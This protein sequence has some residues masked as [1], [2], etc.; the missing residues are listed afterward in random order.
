[1][2]PITIVIVED[3][4]LQVESL[5][6]SLAV[7]RNVQI[8]EIRTER[9]FRVGFDQ[10]AAAQPDV[11]LMDVM[12]RWTDPAPNMEPPPDEVRSQKFYRAGLRCQKMLSQDDRTRDIPVCL[13]TVLERADLES[14]LAD[15]P[16]NVVHIRKESDTRTL[17]E[18]L[19]E[20]IKVKLGV[21]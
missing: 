17:V 11:V 19:R 14:E 18:S 13:Y 5:K 7:L 2:S 10:L 6:V 3:D 20:I 12:L 1:M 16:A 9:A 8:I 21:G 15:L 4:P